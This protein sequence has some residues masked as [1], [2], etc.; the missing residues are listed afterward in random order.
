MR[1]ARFGRFLA[2]E[3]IPAGALGPGEA[4]RLEDRHL[5]DSLGFS[6]AWQGERSPDRLVDV[7]SG[8]G[9]P[10]IPLA[11]LWPECDVR[12]VERSGRR[13]GLLRRASRILDLGNVTVLQASVEDL[14]SSDVSGAAMVMRAVFP[15][16]R[17][18]DEVEHA[19]WE[20]LVVASGGDDVATWGERRCFRVFARVGWVR[21]MRRA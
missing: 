19:A 13:A 21:T 7:G 15:P 8:A 2:D 9:L 14:T 1:L 17:A 20:R 12:L 5:H 6:I 10:G 18:L 3:A 11:I 16:D 4:E